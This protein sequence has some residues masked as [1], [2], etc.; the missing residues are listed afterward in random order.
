MDC[1]VDHLEGKELERLF[2]DAS[3]Y[4]ESIGKKHALKNYDQFALDTS[5]N[6]KFH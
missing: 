6:I 2:N 5:N 1:K 4:F 3:N